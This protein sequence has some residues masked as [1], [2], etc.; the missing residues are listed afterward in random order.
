MSFQ[1]TNDQIREFLTLLATCHTVVPENNTLT[2]SSDD[3][4]YQASSPGR[5]ASVNDRSRPT[6]IRRLDEHALVT[7]VKDMGVVFFR[8]TP[9]SVVIS[10][11]SSE[12]VTIIS[13]NVI[14][15]AAKRKNMKF[16]TS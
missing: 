16:S 2:G 9:D 6:K 12:R 7:A 3:I 15:S 4:I 8:R 11:V 10:F 5:F 1:S 14:F 13:V